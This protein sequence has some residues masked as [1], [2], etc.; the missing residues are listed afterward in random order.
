M[1]PIFALD[2]RICFMDS[3]NLAFMSNEI[4]IINTVEL[5]IGSPKMKI[6]KIEELDGIPTAW[7]YWLD[8]SNKKAEGTFPID[9]LRPV[10]A[11][12][13]IRTKSVRGV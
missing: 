12:T 8:T 7:C 13:R 11:R 1:S 9:A 5:K 3:D 4:K 6:T 2:L 10:K